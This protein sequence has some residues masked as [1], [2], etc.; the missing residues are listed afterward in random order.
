MRNLA[1]YTNRVYLAWK[2]VHPEN[3]HQSLGTTVDLEEFKQIMTEAA[4]IV[5]SFHLGKGFIPK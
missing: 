2:N 5:Q 3:S 1:K 4:H